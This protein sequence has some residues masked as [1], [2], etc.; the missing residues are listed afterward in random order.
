MY[1]QRLVSTRFVGLG[2][3]A[4]GWDT[5]EMEFKGNDTVALVYD[6]VRLVKY[7]GMKISEIILKW[8]T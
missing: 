2:A 4:R 3:L 5:P 6:A 8:L 1:N 7:V